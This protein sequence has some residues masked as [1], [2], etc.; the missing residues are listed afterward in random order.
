M[1]V[2]G[3]NKYYELNI[4]FT[5]QVIGKKH[6]KKKWPHSRMP[7]RQPPLKTNPLT[8][9]YKHTHKPWQI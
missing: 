1:P 7:Q 9:H 8:E 5:N 3:W 2:V 4:A 6:I